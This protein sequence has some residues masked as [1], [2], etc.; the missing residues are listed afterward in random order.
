M[1][2]QFNSA[3]SVKANEELKAPIIALLSE[4]L[5]RFSQQIMRLDVHL[6]DENG[7]KEGPNDKRC[8]LEAHLEGRLPLVA[9][10]HAASYELAAEGA[11][12]KLKGSLNSALDRS[13]EHRQH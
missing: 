3:H 4:K 13:H 7:D 8:L 10:N 11:V 12:E 2:I 9:K 6:S 5:H 1:T